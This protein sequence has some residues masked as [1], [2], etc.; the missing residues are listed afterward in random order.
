M[1]TKQNAKKPENEKRIVTKSGFSFTPLEHIL[2][3]WDFIAKMGR[4]ASPDL[5]ETESLAGYFDVVN[6]L[7]PPDDLERLKAHVREEK[8]YCSFAAMRA[9]IEEIIS[10]MRE[11][12][13]N[14]SSSP[15]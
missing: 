4:M 3:D 11:A 5:T 15:E 10:K 7:L 12:E 9:E 2:D 14:S 13:G 1:S 8:G 6:A